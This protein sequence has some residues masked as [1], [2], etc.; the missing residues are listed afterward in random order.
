M[1]F[2]LSIKFGDT[3]S[4]LQQPDAAA[5]NLQLLKKIGRQSYSGVLNFEHDGLF[6]GGGIMD[7]RRGEDATTTVV[8]WTETLV[9]PWLPA[10][11]WLI[12]R[13]I[14]AALYRRDLELL[15]DVVEDTFVPAA[16]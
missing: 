10:F 6:K 14:I 13:P 11:G 8:A 9:P 2:E 1:E 12:G 15:R 4:H 3:F 16:A 7:L 5:F